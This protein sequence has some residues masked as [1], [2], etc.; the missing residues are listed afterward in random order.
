M[1]MY[2]IMASISG[3]FTWTSCTLTNSTPIVTI[4][5]F[6]AVSSAECDNIFWNK[7]EETLF[8]WSMWPTFL[9]IFYY[10]YHSLWENGCRWCSLLKSGVE[11]V[12][13]LSSSLTFITL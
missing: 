4:W 8:S 1:M 11:Q 2:E 10:P 9:Q 6:L 13:F 7:F 12:N 3:T 5:D